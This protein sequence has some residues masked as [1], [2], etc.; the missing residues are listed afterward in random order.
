MNSLEKYLE[1]F[2]AEYKIAAQPFEFVLTYNIEAILNVWGKKGLFNSINIHSNISDGY[3]PSMHFDFY[4]SARQTNNKYHIFGTDHGPCDY[5][6]NKK[7]GEIALLEII[8]GK[9][10]FN[11]AKDEVSF[12]QVLTKMIE[13]ENYY[14]KKVHVDGTLTRKIRAEC[15]NLAGGENYAKLYRYI[16]ISEE[17]MPTD[18]FTLP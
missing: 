4:F 2:F 7:S 14:L 11:I 12:L 9:F 17:D 15:I 8:T 3:Q 5:A 10:F 18:E 16:I 6:I 1:D 13:F